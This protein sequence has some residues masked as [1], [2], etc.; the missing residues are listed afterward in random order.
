LSTLTKVLIILQVVVVLVLCGL[1]VTYVATSD[2]YKKMCDDQR[3]QATRA[4]QGK[5]QAEEELE[6]TKAA[7]DQEI[8]AFRQQIAA[9]TEKTN[10]MTQDA[11]NLAREMDRLKGENEKMTLAVQVANNTALQQ[12]DLFKK[13][14]EKNEA[15]SAD[16]IKKDGE[17]R[18]A[19]DA[20]TEKTA[21]LTTQTTQIRSLADQTKELQSKLDQF[22]RLTGRPSPPPTTT[23]AASVEQTPNLKGSITQVDP[24]NKLAEISIGAND[25]VKPNME[26]S[27]TRGNQFVCSLVILDARPQKAV[28]TI[29]K[30][31]QEPK[32]GDVASTN[33]YE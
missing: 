24:G 14:Q 6:K 11:A 17:L 32:V 15:L 2:N 16:V 8:A 31:Q 25:G 10:A 4:N 20:L 12:T 22:Q 29:D 30:A 5:A 9:L 27:I 1:V 19:S 23:S 13:A 7:K 28:G 18:Q 3:T 33:L 26:F 21:L